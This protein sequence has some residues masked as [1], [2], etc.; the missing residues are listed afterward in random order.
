MAQAISIADAVAVVLEAAGRP[1]SI[2]ELVQ[3]C[4]PYVLDD[5]VSYFDVKQCCLHLFEQKL[6]YLDGADPLTFGWL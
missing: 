4:K 1:M 2:Y 5:F 3:E 6:V